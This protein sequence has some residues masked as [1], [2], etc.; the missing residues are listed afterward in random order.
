M[1]ERFKA[2]VWTRGLEGPLAGFAMQDLRHT[3]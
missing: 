3:L 2:M 1:G